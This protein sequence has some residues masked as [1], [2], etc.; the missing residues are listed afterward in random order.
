MKF[1][2]TASSIIIS[3]LVCACVLA[4]V[5]TLG[6]AKE[7]Y[8]QVEDFIS[9]L[10]NIGDLGLS[11]EAKSMDRTLAKSLAINDI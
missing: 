9:S 3:L 6:L 10:T 11:V 5:F 4:L 2:V 7:G 8:D 1:R